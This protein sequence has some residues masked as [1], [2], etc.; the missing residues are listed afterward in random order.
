MESL[1]L[2]TQEIINPFIEAMIALF[3]VHLTKERLA[4]M[5]Q[6]PVSSAPSSSVLCDSPDSGIIS[7]SDIKSDSY[8]STDDETEY[9]NLIEEVDDEDDE[10]EE[11]AEEDENICLEYPLSTKRRR[12]I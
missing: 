11:D 12:V 5:P 8:S 10:T 7:S 9:M 4:S 1:T 2:C 6:T 3:K